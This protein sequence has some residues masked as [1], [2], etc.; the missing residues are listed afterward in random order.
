MVISAFF[1]PGVIGTTRTLTI[2]RRIPPAAERTGRTRW[3]EP[4][5]KKC[6]ALAR[7]GIDGVARLTRHPTVQVGGVSRRAVIGGLKP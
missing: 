2:T 1:A 4:F 7:G 3:T 6:R 5:D